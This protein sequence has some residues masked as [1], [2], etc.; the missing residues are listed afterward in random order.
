MESDSNESAILRQNHATQTC[1]CAQRSETRPNEFDDQS[2]SEYNTDSYET[3]T[4]NDSSSDW[5]DDFSEIDSNESAILRQDHA[6]QTCRCAQRSETRPHEF[7]DQSSSEYDTDSYDTETIEE[8]GYDEAITEND[9]SS[10][11]SDDYSESNDSNEANEP[12]L[13][14]TDADQAPRSGLFCRC[15]AIRTCRCRSSPPNHVDAISNEEFYEFLSPNINYD[16]DTESSNYSNDSSLEM[17]NQTIGNR[18]QSRDELASR[19]QAETSSETSSYD[20]NE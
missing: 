10:D 4:E 6:M 20:T 15:H 16:F 11:W 9:F 3:E 14:E 8:D 2:S 18:R 12:D 17:A 5:S 13:P 19:Y 1:R 7:D